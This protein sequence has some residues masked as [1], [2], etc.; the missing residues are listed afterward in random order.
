VTAPPGI[1]LRR[2][3]RNADAAA[4]ADLVARTGFF[5]DEEVAIARE[6]VESALASGR[7][8]GYEFVL[9]DSAAGLAGYTCFGRIPGTEAS[10]DLYWVVVAPSLQGQGVGRW[11]VGETESAVRS[12]GGTRLYVDTS[13]RPQ[14]TPTRRFYE[15]CGYTVAAELPDF[16][17]AGDGKVI[18][19]KPLGGG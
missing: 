5:S 3:P 8:S 9:A 4:V 19:V 15:A 14:Y 18:F 11:L 17:R 6:L 16:Y 13:S 7:A 12:M 1:S 10:F 2:D